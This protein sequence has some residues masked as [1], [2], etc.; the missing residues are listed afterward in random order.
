MAGVGMAPPMMNNMVA[1]PA[2]NQPAV[3]AVMEMESLASGDIGSMAESTRTG[4]GR[5]R[6]KAAITGNTLAVNV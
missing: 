5:R 6:R 3:A 2:M 1:P 4:G